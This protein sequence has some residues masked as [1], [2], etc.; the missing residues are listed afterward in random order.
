[1]MDT[2]TSDGVFFFPPNVTVALADAADDNG[3]ADTEVTSGTSDKDCNLFTFVL[4][5]GVFG[6]MCVFGLVGNTVSFVVLQWEKQNKVA[7][8]LLQVSLQALRYLA[9]NIMY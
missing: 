8:F 3:G 5:V 2:Y 6:S 1:M 7:T 4:Y 9:N